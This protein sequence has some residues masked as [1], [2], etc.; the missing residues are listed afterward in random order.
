MIERHSITD[1]SG[2]IDRPAWLALRVNDIT[3][4]DI[5]AVCGFGLYGSAAKVW[6]EKRGLLPPQEMTAAME[7]GLWGEAAVF[8][9][10]ASCYPDWELR[11]AKVYLRDTDHRIGAT[12]DGAAIVPG[13]DGVVIVQCKVIAA[14]VF[15]ASWLDNPDDDIEYG[16][17]TAPMAYQLQ[18][19]TE[20]DLSE[21]TCGVLAVLVVDAF[22][23]VL[24]TFWIERHPEAQASIREKVGVFFRDY[25]D[26]GIQPPIQPTLDSEL[27]KKLFPHDDGLEIDLS[28]NNRIIDLVDRREDIKR[29]MK[30]DKDA[31]DEIET[32]IKGVLGN[33]A[34]GR[35]ADGRVVSWKLQYRKGYE[36]K[37]TEYRVLKV[38]NGGR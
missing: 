5:G 26:P 8:E 11:R 30:A 28:E 1:A 25:L 10:L 34:Y 33:A 3:A 32:E 37:P 24:R 15:K 35:L 14:P 36:V 31:L 18:T 7:R 17:A 16:T 29:T 19:L 4:S 2:R 21:A 27:V 12:P 22:K 23:W 38:A 20:V 9:A 13:R 6:A